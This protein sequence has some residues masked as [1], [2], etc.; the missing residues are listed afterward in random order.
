MHDTVIQGC[1]G[2]STLLEASAGF[3]AVDRTESEKL[4]DQAR[5]QVTRTLEEAR[6]A[7]WDLRHPQPAESEVAVLFDLA[8]E[9]AAEHRIEIHTQTEGSGSVDRDLERTILFVG[10]EALSN[11]ITHARASRIG[12]RGQLHAVRCES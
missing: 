7:V 12:I 8:R 1:V 3:R 4:I 2:V 5:M 6:D 9:L 11:A 10:R